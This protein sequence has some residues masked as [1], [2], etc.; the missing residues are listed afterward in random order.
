MYIWGAPKQGP[1]TAAAARGKTHV[2]QTAG[3]SFKESDQG[4]EGER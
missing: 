3:G 4:T 1:Q 2:Q